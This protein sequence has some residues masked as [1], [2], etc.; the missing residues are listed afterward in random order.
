MDDETLKTYAYISISSYRVKT[1]KAM[2]DDVKIPTQI[3]KD[4][5]ILPIHITK[6]LKE[7]KE[8]KIVECINEEARKERLYRLTSVGDEIADFE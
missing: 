2:N 8:V 3:A 1:M 4:T 7:L 6:V 5:G